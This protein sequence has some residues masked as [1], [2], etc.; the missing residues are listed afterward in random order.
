[1]AAAAAFSFAQES[2]EPEEEEEHH[3]NYDL[4]PLCLSHKEV[5]SH[6]PLPCRRRRH[7]KALVLP[8][9]ALLGTLTRLVTRLDSNLYRTYFDNRSS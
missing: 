9:R 6:L 3:H 5:P 8:K 2:E 4:L 7:P 1:M